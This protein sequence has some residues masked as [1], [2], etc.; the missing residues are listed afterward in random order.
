MKHKF[1]IEKKERDIYMYIYQ[2]TYKYHICVDNY[3][4]GELNEENNKNLYFIIYF[5]LNIFLL[6]NK[7]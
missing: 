3:E 6:Q 1:Q 5:I 2:Y 4:N 7:S